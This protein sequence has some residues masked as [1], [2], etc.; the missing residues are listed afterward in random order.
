MNAHSDPSAWKPATLGD[1]VEFQ[2]GF[3]ITVAE[4]ADGE[5]P[6]VSSSGI[7]SYHSQARVCGPGVV[8][9]RK[10]TLGGVYFVESDFWPHDT[11]LWVKDFKGHDPK[12]VYYQL[13]TIDFL[14]FN[15]GNANP[16]LNRNHIRDIPLLLPDPD[17]QR[18]IA[19]KLSTFDDLIANNQRRITLLEYAA[20]QLYREWFVRLRFPGSEHTVFVGGIPDGWQRMPVAAAVSVNPRT[21]LSNVDEHCSV[22]MADLSE[23]S[24]VIESWSTS[25]RRSG[26]K[27]QN[28]DTLFARITPC[29]ENGKTGF[30]DFLA[31]GEAARGST[32]FIVLRARELTAE[33]IYCLA[34]MPE[35]REHARVSMVGASGR[36]RVQESCFERFPVLVPSPRI[37]DHFTNIVRPL[38]EQIRV[39]TRQNAQLRTARDLLLPRLMSG[40]ISL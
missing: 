24:M 37:A 7:T 40:R 28:G 5:Y 39:L 20:R 38:F 26:S 13:R 36:Q 22:E 33:A 16:T 10:G 30:V 2:R 6:V 34:R 11:T 17:V 29:L 32:E 14:R 15:V 9:G 19:Q 27:F 4:Q 18:L 25:S 1:L 3:D 31:P 23:S 35:F 21:P 12:F 8:I